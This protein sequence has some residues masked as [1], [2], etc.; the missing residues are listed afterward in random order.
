MFFFV[1]AVAVVVD[2]DDVDVPTGS[3]SY[4]FFS[5]YNAIIQSFH[6]FFLEKSSLASIHPLDDDSI[7][8]NK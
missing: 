8:N 2:D 1:F 7:I 6:F 5:L 4:F 3:I